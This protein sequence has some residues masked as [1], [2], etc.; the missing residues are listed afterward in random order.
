MILNFNSLQSSYSGYAAADEAGVPSHISESSTI[1][2]A[3][4]PTHE[5]CS[6]PNFHQVH[7]VS[8][9]FYLALPI[10]TNG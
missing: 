5:V 8:M 6:A 10:L 7:Q 3:D 9:F 1:S 2:D 4:I